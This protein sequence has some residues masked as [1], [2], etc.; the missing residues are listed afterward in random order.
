MSDNKKVF[1]VLTNQSNPSYEAFIKEI[2]K[3]LDP[4]MDLEIL[5]YTKLLNSVG[6]A[7]LARMRFN[8]ILFTGGEDVDPTYYHEDKG[9]YTSSNRRRDDIEA[10]MFHLFKNVPK[11]GICRGSQFLTVM[12][13]GKL[14]QHVSN[15]GISGTHS[16]TL[17]D[18]SIIE[19]TSTHHQMMFPFSLPSDMFEL[20]GWSTYFKSTTYLNGYNKETELPSDFL[21]PEIVKYPMFNSLCI[22]GHPEYMDYSSDSVKTIINLI[23]TTI[24]K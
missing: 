16:V 24:L 23:I 19:I 13:G 2:V 12:N 20:I 1:R 21:E 10:D 6:M 11:L 3:T 4:S 17:N 9:K 14:I 8:L 7:D 5:N 22:Q 15:H 18:K